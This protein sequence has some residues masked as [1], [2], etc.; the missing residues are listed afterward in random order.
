MATYK[1]PLINKSQRLTVQLGAE[2]YI[3]TV[4]WNALVNLWF[5]GIYDSGSSPL[6]LNIPLVA[7]ADL[8]APQETVGIPGKLLALQDGN[9]FLPPSYSDLGVT[10]NVY[11]VTT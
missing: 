8:L 9:G 11:F 6:L 4:D 2:T 3:L 10:S 5:V 1:L 7:G